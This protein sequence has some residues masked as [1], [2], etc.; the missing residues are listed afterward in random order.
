ML[1]LRLLIRFSAAGSKTTHTDSAFDN[2]NIIDN[3]IVNMAARFIE[4]NCCQKIDVTDVAK[5]VHLSYSHLSRLF[6]L[7]LGESLNHYINKARLKKAQYLLKCSD[8]DI[9]SIASESGFRSSI[10][11]CSIF[12]KTIGM[13]PGHYRRSATGLTD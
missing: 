8:K 6:K 5:S 13:S 4:E 2:R 3:N 7:H 1:F 12:K 11:F 9:D 10:Y